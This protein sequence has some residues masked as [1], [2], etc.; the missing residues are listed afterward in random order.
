MSTWEYRI[1]NVQAYA[2]VDRSAEAI[3]TDG[4]NALGDEGWDLVTVDRF[5]E[6]VESR[7]GTVTRVTFRAFL[8]RPKQPA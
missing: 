7:S 5:N 2:T 3:A 4:L 6:M 1:T 8:K